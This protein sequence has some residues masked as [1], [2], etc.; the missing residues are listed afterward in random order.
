LS[1]SSNLVDRFAAINFFEDGFL[2]D[3]RFSRSFVDRVS[4]HGLNKALSK[5]SRN[6]RERYRRY[7]ADY[8]VFPISISQSD[9][10]DACRRAFGCMVH[11]TYSAQFLGRAA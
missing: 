7:L 10:T 8:Q 4:K 3:E 11:R 5:L 6:K 9:F 2:D 1:Q